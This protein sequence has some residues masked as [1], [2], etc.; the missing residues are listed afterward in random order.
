MRRERAVERGARRLVVALRGRDER[1]AAARHRAA[2]RVLRGRH[3]AECRRDREGVVEPARRG[4]RLAEHVGDGKIDGL[5]MPAACILAHAGSSTAIAPSASSSVSATR[6]STPRCDVSYQT[7]SIASVR[8]S[9]SRATARAPSWS[10]RTACTYA[11]GKAVAR[12]SA[13][14][15]PDARARG[16]PGIGERG[17]PVAGRGPDLREV[18]PGQ[19]LDDLEA[20]L[21]GRRDLVSQ[22]RRGGVELAGVHARAPECEPR[23]VGIGRGRRCRPSDRRRG[24]RSR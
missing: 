5:P 12:W 13:R 17:R 14:W 1:L 22:Q 20:L 7:S 10:P 23:R 19:H 9:P 16:R 2:P 8:A 15:R 11:S 4:V 21:V 3:G 18:V 24:A 6:P